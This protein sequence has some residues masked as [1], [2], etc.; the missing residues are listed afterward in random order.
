MALADPILLE[1]LRNRFEAIADEMEL[2]ILK[3][4]YSPIVKEGLD[5]S[6]ALFGARGET[7]AQGTGIPIHLGSLIFAVKRM[8]EAFPP[9]TMAEGDAYLLN[10]PYDGGTHLPD[11]VVVVPVRWGGRT[12]ALA[13]TMC[14][15]QDVGGKTPG[16]IP[17]DAPE[18]YQEGLVIP[19]CRPNSSPIR[20][21]P[22]RPAAIC[23][24]RSPTTTSGMRTFRRMKA[25]TVGSGSPARNS[26]H[27]GM[28]R[29][30][31]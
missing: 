1:V 21:A 4:A 5:A 25:S 16:S 28:T 20:A 12:V 26:R 9:D 11:W 24:M 14:H 2:T 27:G 13:T 7:I 8:I 15:H 31:W 18:I 17:T 6:S 19:P 30:S 3:S 10:D 23:A 29:P 22:R